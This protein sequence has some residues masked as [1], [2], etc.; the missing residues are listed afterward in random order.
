MRKYNNRLGVWMIALLIVV[1]ALSLSSCLTL[2]GIKGGSGGK[3]V[4]MSDIKSE[5]RGIR[6][7][8]AKATTSFLKGSAKVFSA[9]GKKEEAMKYEQAAEELENNPEDPQKIKDSLRIA[10]EANKSLEEIKTENARVSAEGKKELGRGI[11]HVGAGGM[12]DI[13]AASKAADFV[14]TLKNALGV[15]QKD[16]VKYGVSAVNTLKGSL[17]L[18]AFLSLELPNQGAAISNTFTGLIKYAGTNGVTV[19]KAD[20]EKEAAKME[21]G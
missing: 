1:F 8:V 16:P 17:D 4:N 13:A 10:D 18:M 12:L 9:V 3:S 14:Q 19:T 20:A 7:L 6:I 21:K 2:E 11:V 15:V 5:D